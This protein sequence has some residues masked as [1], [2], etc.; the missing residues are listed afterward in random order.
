MTELHRSA[1]ATRRF[2]APARVRGTSWQPLS[3]ALEGASLA[4]VKRRTPRARRRMV[5]PS[6]LDRARFCA[7]LVA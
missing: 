6:R 1:A 5:A 3:R 7:T 2:L 4:R